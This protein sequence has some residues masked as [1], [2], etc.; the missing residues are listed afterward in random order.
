MEEK[1]IKE[2]GEFGLID[3]LTNSFVS[4]NANTIK[5]IGDDAAVIKRGDKAVLIS[6]DML[7]EGIHFDMMYSPL[8][9][10]GYKSVVVNLSDIYA[11]NAIPSHITMSI[12]ISSKY[13]TAAMQEL[14][15]GIKKACEFY[16][17]DLIGGDTTSSLK[18]LIISVTAYGTA[19][20]NDVVYRSGAKNGDVICVTGDLGAA[21]LGLQILEREKRLYIDNPGVQP[22]L[23]K[24]QYLI[25]RQLKPEARKDT[26]EFFKNNGLKPTAM[27]D[28]SDGL[29]SDIMHICKQSKLG[30][31]I[32]EGKV[33]MHD[34]TQ[35]MAIDFRLD[36]ITCALSGGEDY[37]LL[38]CI[39]PKD[40]DKVRYMP[41]VAIIGEMNDVNDGIKLHTTGGNIFPLKAQGWN[42]L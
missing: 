39:D 28:V 27:I 33:P 14:Y 24:H 19:D 9:H 10:L 8:M 42:H 1:N 11:M 5:G 4:N 37:E 23:N 41:G 3:E 12:A 13:D 30:A 34:E 22:E 21:Y 2:L 40:I 17:V 16:N 25:E 15:K 18:G 20:E 31:F 36:P 29:S 32:E 6:T 38:F 35:M 7:V 26:I